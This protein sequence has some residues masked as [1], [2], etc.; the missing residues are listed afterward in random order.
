MKE[1]IELL[2]EDT[3]REGL[4]K[5]PVRYEKAMHYLMSGY[6]QSLAGIVNGERS[7]ASNAMRW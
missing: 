1:V 3:S 2:G 6:Q 5:T 4:V 7:S